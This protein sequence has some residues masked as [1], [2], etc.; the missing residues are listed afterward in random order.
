M[1]ALD[2]IF[3][4]VKAVFNTDSFTLLFL[5]IWPGPY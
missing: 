4:A 1:L 2:A 5:F 3:A